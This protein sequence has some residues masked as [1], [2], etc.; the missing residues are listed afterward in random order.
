MKRASIITL[1][2]GD[3]M[4]CIEINGV[5]NKAIQQLERRGYKSRLWGYSFALMNEVAIPLL[6]FYR[7]PGALHGQDDYVE[8]VPE[9]REI[10]QDVTHDGGPVVRLALV[11]KFNR[12]VVGWE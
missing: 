11:D 2:A 5:P 7:D 3:R 10:V 4:R 8:I 1:L 6:E 9:F 12:I